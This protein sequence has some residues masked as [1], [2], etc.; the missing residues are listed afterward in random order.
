MKDV[1]CDAVKYL[2]ESEDS[3]PDDSSEDG[4]MGIRSLS[5]VE[6]S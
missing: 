2:S 6:G 1:A 4:L 3:V 5:E